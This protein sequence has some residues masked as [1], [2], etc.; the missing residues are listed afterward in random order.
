MCVVRVLIFLLPI[1]GS[2]VGPAQMGPIV[3]AKGRTEG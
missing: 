1:M 3:L 2:K